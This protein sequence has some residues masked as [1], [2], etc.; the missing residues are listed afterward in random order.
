[1]PLCSRARRAASPSGDPALRATPSRLPLPTSPRRP[2]GY[3]CVRAARDPAAC[4]G[5]SVSGNPRNRSSPPRLRIAATTPHPLWRGAIEALRVGPC[6]RLGPSPEMMAI[7]P[8]RPFP[9]TTSASCVLTSPPFPR[10]FHRS[11]PPPDPRAGTPSGISILLWPR[12]LAVSR[13]SSFFRH[14]SPDAGPKPLWA[15]L[16]PPSLSSSATSGRAVP[17]S[18]PRL[19]VGPLGNRLRRHP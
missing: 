19:R 6:P 3:R 4:L 10:S 7:Y 17:C 13:A 9:G 11:D 5:P 2:S 18:P 16:Q 1:M 12:L 15:D 8:G 14:G